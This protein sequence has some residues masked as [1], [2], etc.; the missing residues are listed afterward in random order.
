VE[1]NDPKAG[2]LAVQIGEDTYIFPQEKKRTRTPKAAEGQAVE[3]LHMRV[4]PE[5]K[6]LLG[7]LAAKLG[8]KD[9]EAVIIAVREKAASEGVK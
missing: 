8:M 1:A 7:R 9:T 4:T 3:R 2:A 6:G 5:F